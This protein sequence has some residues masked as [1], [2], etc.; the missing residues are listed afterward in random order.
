MHKVTVRMGIAGFPEVVTLEVGARYAAMVA[1]AGQARELADIVTGL[2]DPPAGAAASSDA[3][4]R[5]VP[6][7]GGLLPHLTVL[8]NLVRAFRVAR[9]RV[10]VATAVES[11]QVLA[12]Q[13]ALG[14]VLDR[15]PYEIAPGRR[16]LAGVARALCAEPTVIVL[17]DAAGLPTWDVLLGPDRNP[18]LLGVALLLVTTT[19]GRAAGFRELGVA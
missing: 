12:R 1:D 9:K 15:Y 14:D 19:R 5:L 6:A 10:P 7:E 2:A 16:R 17:E 4:I 3:R 13:C 18:G 11:C 8:K